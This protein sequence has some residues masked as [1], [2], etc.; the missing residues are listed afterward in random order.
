M[1][2]RDNEAVKR[3]S[4]SVYKQAKA[5]YNEVLFSFLDSFLAIIEEV[6]V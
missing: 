1:K 3:S 2:P 5:K 6:I 4:L